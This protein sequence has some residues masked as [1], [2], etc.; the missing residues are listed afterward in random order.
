MYQNETPY[1]Y[2]EMIEIEKG[3]YEKLVIRDDEVPVEVNI[4]EIL[5]RDIEVFNDKEYNMPQ[6]IFLIEGYE[7]NVIVGR[8]IWSVLSREGKINAINCSMLTS[9]MLLGIL[10]SC[11]RKKP[12][13]RV[14]YFPLKNGEKLTIFDSVKRNLNNDVYYPFNFRDYASGQEKESPKTGWPFN[15]ERKAYLGYGEYHIREFTK[16]YFNG[17]NMENMIVYD[18]ACSTGEFL[19][20]FKKNHN[21]CITIGHDLSSEM[22]AYA[23]DFVDEALCCDAIESPLPDGSVDIMFLRFLNSEVVCTGKAHAN[24]EKLISK[25][26]TK[27]RIVCFG[28]TPVL[29]KLEWCEAHGLRCL[30]KIGYDD[31]HDAIFQYYVFER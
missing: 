11:Y 9:S 27:G 20:T 5:G 1:S 28:H 7:G 23:K 8:K 26:K 24:M 16:K 22:I 31:D 4:N 19:N 2:E 6:N 14:E 15:L 25:V 30:N 29:I 12:N 13:I 17:E 3:I 18:P 21:T 10:K